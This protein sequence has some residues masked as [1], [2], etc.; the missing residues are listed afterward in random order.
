M[1]WNKKTD[2]ISSINT[3]KCTGCGN[4]IDKCR[5]HVLN[6]TTNGGKKQAVV[7]HASRCV[8]CG[9]CAR[10][11]KHGAIDLIEKDSYKNIMDLI[12]NKEVQ[13]G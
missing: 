7:H 3:H 11:C 4:C 9:N 5:G 6:I 13:Y 12:W 2:L 8:G 1:F 10:F